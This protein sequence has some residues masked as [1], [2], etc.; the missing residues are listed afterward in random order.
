MF[1][2]GNFTRKGINDVILYMRTY[3]IHN[4]IGKADLVAGLEIHYRKIARSLWIEQEHYLK[5]SNRVDVF[6][7]NRHT[8]LLYLLKHKDALLRE[9]VLG[10][11]GA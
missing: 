6:L 2:N 7:E 8:C 4:P 3:N 11:Y 5:G 10:V 1:L 9:I